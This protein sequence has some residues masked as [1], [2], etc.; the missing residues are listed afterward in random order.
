MHQMKTFSQYL[1]ENAPIL[2]EELQF[3]GKKDSAE[4]ADEHK[5]AK[6]MA[7]L[8]NYHGDVKRGHRAEVCE[9][10]HAD[11]DHCIHVKELKK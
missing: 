3:K 6:K 7:A 1:K 2:T 5:K 8:M 10:P 4:Y 11:G 9:E